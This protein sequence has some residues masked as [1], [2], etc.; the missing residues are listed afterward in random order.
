MRNDIVVFDV[1]TGGLDP[2]K[3]G[4]CSITMKKYGDENLIKTWY[5][6]P[7]KDLLYEQGAF[8]VNGFFS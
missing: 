5:V 2:S 1:E 8:N 7:N 3:N 6:K 4:L